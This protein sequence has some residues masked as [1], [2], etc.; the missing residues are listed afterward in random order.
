MTPLGAT[1]VAGR[2]R[3]NGVEV[4]I[5]GATTTPFSCAFP[6]L[7]EP[8]DCHRMEDLKEWDEFATS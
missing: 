8:H 3:E 1:R 7:G 2:P 6:P 5:G 4:V